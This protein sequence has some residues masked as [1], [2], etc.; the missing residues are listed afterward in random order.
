MKQGEYI[1]DRTDLV[2]DN[3]INVEIGG[4]HYITR[5]AYRKSAYVLLLR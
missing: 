3:P 1:S 4:K 5:P 2:N